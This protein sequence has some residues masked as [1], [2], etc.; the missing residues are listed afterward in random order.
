MFSPNRLFRPIDVTG[1]ASGPSC[2]LDLSRRPLRRP[3]EST[4]FRLLAACCRWPPSAQRDAAVARAADGVDWT[5]F[6]ALIKRHRVEGLAHAALAVAAVRPPAPIAQALAARA[7]DIARQGLIQAAQS[8]RLQALFD[9]AGIANLVLKGAALDQL[10]YGRLGLKSAWDIDLLV[11]PAMAARARALLET[12]G[13]E[14]T[15]PAAST[16]QAFAQWTALSKESVFVGR[17]TGVVVELHWRLVDGDLLPGLSADSPGQSVALSA[18]TV[19]RTLAPD[20]LVAYLMVHGAAHGWSRLK[21]LADLNA[22]LPGDDPAA[23]E[24]VYRRSVA[25][26]AGVC[27][28]VAIRLCRRLFGL[29]VAAPLWREID[30]DLKARALERVALNAMAGGAGRETADRPFV[31]DAILASR[32]LFADGRDWRRGEW[33]RQWVSVHDR[34]HIRLPAPFGFLYGVVRVPLWLWRRVRRP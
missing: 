18:E 8:A 24:D 21:W 9:T 32:L 26:G 13:Y 4:P 23:L 28:A 1:A 27:P 10:A 31:E 29:A 2:M 14:M 16:A 6:A 34:T 30:A 12:A 11:P 3:W 20:A 5:V 7:G 17:G 33:R 19:L 22:L 15:I 25:L